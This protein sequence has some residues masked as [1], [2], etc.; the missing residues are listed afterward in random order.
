MIRSQYVPLN[1]RIRRV[2]LWMWQDVPDLGC[3]ECCN[4]CCIEGRGGLKEFM[5]RDIRSKSSNPREEGEARAGALARSLQPPKERSPR[6][7]FGPAAEK[8]WLTDMPSAAFF[9]HLFS[10]IIEKNHR[11][12]KNRGGE[13]PSS[14]FDDLDLYL[15]SRSAKSRSIE[16]KLHNAYP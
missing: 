1:L 14:K 15:L 12:S 6:L 11:P 13:R 16:N 2:N 8:D 10:R 5:R 7:F 4:M 3:H 9:W